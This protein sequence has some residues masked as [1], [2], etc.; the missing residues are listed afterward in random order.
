MFVGSVTQSKKHSNYAD[1]G[2]AGAAFGGLGGHTQ[3]TPDEMPTIDSYVQV[4]FKVVATDMKIPLQ[5][6]WCVPNNL[7]DQVYYT[8][9]ADGD[10]WVYK[11][12]CDTLLSEVLCFNSYN[13]TN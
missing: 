10:V 5:V 2:H 11:A 1:L 3:F 9:D 4:I 6:L 8:I 12:C 7:A 13:R